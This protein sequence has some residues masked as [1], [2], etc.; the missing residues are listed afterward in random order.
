MRSVY[1]WQGKIE[2][3]SEVSLYIKTVTTHY[4]ELEAVIK[5]SHPYAVPEI[6]AIP[7]VDGLPV[8]L[9][10]LKQEVDKEWNV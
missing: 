1:Q 5:Q 10:W 9:D 2:E 4:A 6:I 8:Y 7:I 3:A